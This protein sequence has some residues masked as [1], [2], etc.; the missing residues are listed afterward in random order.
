MNNHGVVCRLGV[1]AG[2]GPG[3]GRCSIRLC[4]QRHQVGVVSPGCWDH[5]GGVIRHRPLCA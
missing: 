4:L 1:V 3:L 5:L 2:I